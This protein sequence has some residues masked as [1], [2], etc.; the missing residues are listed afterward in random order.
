MKNYDQN[1]TG[2]EATAHLDS[3][4][5]ANEC[6]E[7]IALFYDHKKKKIVV[8]KVKLMKKDYYLVKMTFIVRAR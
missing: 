5:I 1:P 3:K 8:L 7:W 4:I 6:L 2:L